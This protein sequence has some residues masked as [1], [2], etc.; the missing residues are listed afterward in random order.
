[1]NSIPSF[2]VFLSK[3][4]VRHFFFSN[5]WYSGPFSAPND[6][7][8]LLFLLYSSFSHSVIPSQPQDLL[9]VMK[10]QRFYI[11]LGNK[12][13]KPKFPSPCSQATARQGLEIFFCFVLGLVGFFAPGG[14]V[15][16]LNSFASAWENHMYCLDYFWLR[17]SAMLQSFALESCYLH[18]VTTVQRHIAQSR[19]QLA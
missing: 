13:T 17:P 9:L 10:G 15:F 6:S 16:A 5:P 7:F 19:L 3:Q 1:M 2:Q 18:K 14:S 12:S 4:M 8:F 11:T